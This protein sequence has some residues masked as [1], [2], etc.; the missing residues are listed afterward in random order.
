M[1]DIVGEAIT[2]DQE[3]SRQV[4]KFSW[5]FES[6]E[7]DPSD[8]RKKYFQL[9]VA[10]GLKKRGKSSGEDFKTEISLLPVEVSYVP[11]V[12]DGERGGRRG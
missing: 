12:M 8:S 5:V 3:L 9:P 11:V 6:E 7:S 10:P 2:L 4:A 1:F